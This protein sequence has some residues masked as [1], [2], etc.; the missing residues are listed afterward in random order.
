MEMKCIHEVGPDSDVRLLP[1]GEGSRHSVETHPLSRVAIRQ[2]LGSSLASQPE[3][4]GAHHV[5]Y[6]FAIAR[7]LRAYP[8]R[9]GHRAPSNRP[10]HSTYAREILNARE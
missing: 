4:P 7:L 6:I 2:P 9:Q 1:E 3:K 8:S 5:S 10:R